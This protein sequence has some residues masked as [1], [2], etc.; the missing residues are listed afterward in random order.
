M[1]RLLS[2]KTDNV[3]ISLMLQQQELHQ[4]PSPSRSTSN[5]EKEPQSLCPQ[6]GQ[7][8]VLQLDSEQLFN[9]MTQST[10]TNNKGFMSRK[11][12]K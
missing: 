10:A 7:V 4:K 1:R 5:L 8:A 9:N 2:R 11:H 6:K 12:A 3:N